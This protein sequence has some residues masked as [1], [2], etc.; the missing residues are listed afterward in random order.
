MIDPAAGLDGGANPDD[1]E[2]AG[3]LGLIRGPRTK[4]PTFLNL[5]SSIAY[6]FAFCFSLFFT[7]ARAFVGLA[8]R[9]AGFS[10]GGLLSMECLLSSA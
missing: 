4:P 6:R 9:F 8:N 5:A 3:S 10:Y 1:D 2:V 7:M